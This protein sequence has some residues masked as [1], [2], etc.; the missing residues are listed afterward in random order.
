MN[1][2]TTTC[3]HTHILRERFGAKCCQEEDEPQREYQHPQVD[4]TMKISTRGTMGN[5]RNNVVMKKKPGSETREKGRWQ[6][7][8]N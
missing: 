3:T 6:P 8:R 4:I 1:I 2:Y 5:H 7:Q